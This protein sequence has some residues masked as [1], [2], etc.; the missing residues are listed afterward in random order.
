MLIEGRA[1]RKALN[2]PKNTSDR[3]GLNAGPVASIIKRIGRLAYFLWVLFSQ[4]A[5][6]ET[7]VHNFEADLWKSFGLTGVLVPDELL[8]ECQ[9]RLH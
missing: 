2:P 9:K 4:T 7:L 8:K 1:Q 3:R 6:D 5:K